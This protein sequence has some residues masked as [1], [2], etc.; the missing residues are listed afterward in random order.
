MVKQGVNKIR[1]VATAGLVMFALA[2]NPAKANHDHNY[3]APLAA[4]I[5]FSALIH[6][7]HKRHYGGHSH[8][9]HKRH[10]GGHSHQDH[11]RHYGHYQYQGH[12]HHR[13][14]SHS[15]GGYQ[16]SKRKH[17]NRW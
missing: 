7:D 5:A 9:G 3:V 12:R 17:Y 13:R 4:F 10:Y 15:H 8:Q 16:A 2:S 14:H 11:Q 6:H 1:L